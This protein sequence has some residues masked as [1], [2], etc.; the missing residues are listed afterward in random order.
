MSVT[1]FIYD[2]FHPY[3]SAEQAGTLYLVAGI[4]FTLWYFPQIVRL[5]KDTTGAAA[6]SLN[7]LLF[8]FILRF[9]GL[10]FS[11]LVLQEPSFWVIFMDTAGRFVILVIASIKRVKFHRSIGDKGNILSVLSP[12]DVDSQVMIDTEKRKHDHEHLITDGVV[13]N[14]PQVIA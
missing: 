3:I 8:Q 12:V 5:L 1:Q 13:P 11:A 2:I 10:L 9:P 4:V 14:K 7:T 6:M